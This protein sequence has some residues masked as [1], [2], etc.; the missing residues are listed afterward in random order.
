[1]V[2][3]FGELLP[4]R[5][6]LL[7]K[8]GVCGTNDIPALARI[9]ARLRDWCVLGWYRYI[10][11]MEDRA[12]DGWIERSGRFHVRHEVDVRDRDAIFSSEISVGLSG[13]ES[14]R[15]IQNPEALQN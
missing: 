7:L 11:R 1:M 3:V 14:T 5:L 9:V 12:E 10:A 8:H 4:L 6:L 13:M 15:E 2:R